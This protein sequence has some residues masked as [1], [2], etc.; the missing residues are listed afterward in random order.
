MKKNKWKLKDIAYPALKT[1]FFVGSL[2]F[3]G[4]AIMILLASDDFGLFLGFVGLAAAY[5]AMFM[6][7]VLSE[8]TID[9]LK[10]KLNKIIKMLEKKKP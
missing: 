8:M 10:K 2:L 9:D 5:L 6:A 3:M 7:V 4:G 1:L